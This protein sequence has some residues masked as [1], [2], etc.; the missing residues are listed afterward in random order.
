MTRLTIV[1]IAAALLGLAALSVAYAHEKPDQLSP[2]AQLPTPTPLPPPGL[3]G[4][5]SGH[6]VFVEFPGAR[7]FDGVSVVSADV[8]QPIPL[9]LLQ[10]FGVDDQNNFVVTGLEGGDYFLLVG[11]TFEPVEPE[12]EEV[13]FEPPAGLPDFLEPLRLSAIRVT[14]P[15]G[16]AVTG[17]E[18]VVTRVDPVFGPTTGAGPS[19]A[20]DASAYMA[21]GLAGLAV[22]LVAGGVALWGRGSRRA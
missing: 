9:S 8:P 11:L 20:N 17:L 7:L 15:D 4:S 19:G 6:I 2:P 22:L 13:L 3:P 10:N 21:A 1:I 16:G 12:P 14:L 5:I 18:I